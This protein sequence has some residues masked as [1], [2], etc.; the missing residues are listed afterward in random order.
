[1]T[2]ARIFASQD[3]ADLARDPYPYVDRVTGARQARPGYLTTF[4]SPR[5]EFLLKLPH[6]TNRALVDVRDAHRRDVATGR[7]EHDV[8]YRGMV[9]II[10]ESPEYEQTEKDHAERVVAR[11]AAIS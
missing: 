11:L 9:T 3:P 2:A 4:H 1:M 6:P 7:V 5:P 8:F 10:A